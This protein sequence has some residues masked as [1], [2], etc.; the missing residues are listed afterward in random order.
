MDKPQEQRG[1]QRLYNKGIF[2]TF[3]GGEGSGKTTQSKLLKSYF[4]AQNI[5]CIWTREIGGTESAEQIRSVI[6]D[7]EL[8]T[9]T[10]MLLA[11][12]AR[13]EH[14]ENLIKPALQQGSIVICDRFVDSTAAYQGSTLGNDLIF[15]MHDEIFNSF[16]PNFTF[17]MNIDPRKALERALIRGDINKFEEKPLEFHYRVQEAFLTISKRFPERIII[18]DADRPQTIIAEE[19]LEA[20]LERLID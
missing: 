20:T 15:S 4:D 1:V 19:I 16:L 9:R 3:E 7:N 2:I 10:E 6:L 11:M 12:A 13:V 18:I 8:D 14:V 5:P 17:Y